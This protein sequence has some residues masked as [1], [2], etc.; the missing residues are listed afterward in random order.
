MT[1]DEFRGLKMGDRIRN[2]MSDSVGTI[3]EVKWYRNALRVSIAWHG[4]PRSFTFSQESTAWMHWTQES[5]K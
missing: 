1:L 3:V 2:S 4:I 5:T